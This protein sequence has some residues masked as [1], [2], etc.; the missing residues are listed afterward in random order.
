MKQK[1]DISELKNSTY[2]IF[3]GLLSVLSIVNIFLVFFIPDPNVSEVATIID[4]ILSVIFLG[5]FTFRIMTATSKTG[6]FFKQFGWADLLASVPIPQLKFLRLFRIF[7]AGRMLKKYGLKNMVNEFSKNR[8]SSALLTLLFMIIMVLEFGAMLMLAVENNTD[9]SNIK[10][11][12]D[13]VWYTFVTIT[14]V[15]Y[16]DRYPVTDV[17]RVIGVLIMIAG[18]G[19]FGT[20]TG[21]LANA[22]LTPPE[23]RKAERK[24]K[25]K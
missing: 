23:V 10:N 17:G 13:A 8:A 11:A 1:E 12:S 6:Y 22:F 7:R 20:L 16:G 24:A 4:G 25:A 2:E 19:L 9:T 5:D 3:I 15:G 18:V 14:T 21:F